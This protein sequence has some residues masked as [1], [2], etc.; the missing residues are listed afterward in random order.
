[1]KAKQ[2]RK[3]DK[4]LSVVIVIFG[5]IAFLSFFGMIGG[6]GNYDLASETHQIMTP[7]E[8]HRTNMI[9]LW[10]TISLVVS[11][12]VIWFCD[13]LQQAVVEELECR[14]QR[15]LARK[16][17]ERIE[18]ERIEEHRAEQWRK[19]FEVIDNFRSHG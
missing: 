14:K 3:L 13:S 5:I 12:A 8:Q 18:Q 4:A 1:M 6:V 10:S 17:K 2:L 15:Y 7:E 16:E 11:G 9:I 19:N